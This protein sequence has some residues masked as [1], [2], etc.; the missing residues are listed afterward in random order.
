MSRFKPNSL[1][2]EFGDF[3]LKV[4]LGLVPG[5]S[6]YEKFS[7]NK[8]L[9]AD[10]ESLVWSLTS[11]PTYTF[12]TSASIDTI[13][14]ASALDTQEI[15]IEGL[16]IDYNFFIQSVTLNGQNKVSITP[17]FRFFRAYNNGSTNLA[18]NVYIYE[19]TTITAGVPDDLSYVKGHI[20]STE[21][22]SLFAAFTVPANKTAYVY[23][24]DASISK[25]PTASNVIIT[26]RFVPQGKAPRTRVRFNLSSTGTSIFQSRDQYITIPEKTDA[27]G[28]ATASAGSTG[29]SINFSAILADN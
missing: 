22:Q 3:I 10:T 7:E 9:A 1:P 20:E 4:K 27:Y 19:N 23:Y 26:V 25:I 14:S 29:V 12:P 2:N 17:L 11:Q 5:M 21:G 15:V 18:G 24:F 8:N 13:S 16:D 28:L 6:I